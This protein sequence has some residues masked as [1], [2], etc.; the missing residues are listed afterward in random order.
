MGKITKVE[1][2][3]FMCLVKEN[4][5]LNFIRLKKVILEFNWWLCVIGF[6]HIH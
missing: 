3:G 1:F 2:V 4:E 5:E 6:V